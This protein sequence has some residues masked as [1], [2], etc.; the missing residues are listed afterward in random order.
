MFRINKISSLLVTILAGKRR[1]D[2][3]WSKC[4]GYQ[5]PRGGS[6]VD[7]WYPLQVNSW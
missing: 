5:A 2:D 1:S 3:R 4:L 6:A 7:K